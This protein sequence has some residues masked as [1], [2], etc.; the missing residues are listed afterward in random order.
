MKAITA[1]FKAKAGYDRSV[2]LCQLRIEDGVTAADG[3]PRA[4]AGETDSEAGSAGSV[5]RFAVRMS[6]KHGIAKNYRI[7]Y[8][9]CEALYAIYA[10]DNCP[11]RWLVAPK[12][13][14]EWISHFNPKLEEITFVC[15]PESVVI[16]SYTQGGFLAIAEGASARDSIKQSLQTELQIDIED[17]DIYDV[18]QYA[19]LTFSFREFRAILTFAE[20]SNYQLSSYFDVGGKPV[21]FSVHATDHISADLVLATL[22]EAMTNTSASSSQPQRQQQRA[23]TPTT[24][25]P[26]PN[27]ARAR[28]HDTARPMDTP[29]R[30]TPNTVP[31]P[32]QPLATPSS[33]LGHTA[34][35]RMSQDD[36]RFFSP[37]SSQGPQSIHFGDDRSAIAPPA[38]TGTPAST[39]RPPAVSSPIGAIPPAP[40]FA[41]PPVSGA[42][43]S[44]PTH[45]P[46]SHAG[47]AMPPTPSIRRL[48][49]DHGAMT[50]S[51]TTSARTASGRRSP[52][53]GP[54]D[55]SV[56]SS[57]AATPLARY[58]ARPAGPPADVYNLDVMTPDSAQQPGGTQ[59]T[60]VTTRSSS[61]GYGGHPAT[62]GYRTP[63]PHL[64]PSTSTTAS[65]GA[66]QSATETPASSS[67]IFGRVNHHTPA[68]RRDLAMVST[69]HEMEETPQVHRAQ[70]LFANDGQVP[71]LAPPAHGAAYPPSSAGASEPGSFGLG[72]S[73]GGGGTGAGTISQGVAS[74]TGPT[75]TGIAA[76]VSSS[77]TTGQKRPRELQSESN[78]RSAVD[79]DRPDEETASDVSEELGATPP[80]SGSRAYTLF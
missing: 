80:P 36:G 53:S 21:L 62:I 72:G 28:T 17:F 73:G 34:W 6:C 25:T 12:L 61:A 38:V 3:D 59:L 22:S 70:L 1:I 55:A 13:M 26:A 46:T 7:F 47:G 63:A 67:P 11:S 16:R 9:P 48:P 57:V 60:S 39:L 24:R 44:R 74:D 75:R 10:K 71:F 32:S 31:P 27:A 41:V 40:S 33:S 5:C 42:R 14:S 78:G 58:P 50:A 45:V 43:T 54:A 52:A 68:D 56:S 51:H 76:A 2:E 66:S 8:E 29:P 35:T 69:D 79:E 77:R 4:G 37:T 30:A 64:A 49:M 18:R 23:A 19:E 20:Q 15:T 65:Y